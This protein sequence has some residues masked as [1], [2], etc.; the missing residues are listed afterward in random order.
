VELGKI[1]F[2]SRMVF[3]HHRGTERAGCCK[4][5]VYGTALQKVQRTDPCWGITQICPVVREHPKA[6]SVPC[7]VLADSDTGHS[8]L[9]EIFLLH[10]QFAIS[11]NS[12][13]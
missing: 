9:L 1:S 12:G 2:A 6:I 4:D 8:K 13:R 3:R 7:R 5:S 10:V 11:S